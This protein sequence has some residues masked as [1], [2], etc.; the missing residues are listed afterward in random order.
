M[1][2][3]ETTTSWVLGALAACAVLLFVYSGSNSGSRIELLSGRSSPQDVAHLRKL[4]K[5]QV[6]A[7]EMHPHLS[8]LLICTFVCMFPVHYSATRKVCACF[9]LH[10]C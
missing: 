9:F 4:V 6:V 2:S 3:K 10:S 1:A 5:D 8:L 7:L